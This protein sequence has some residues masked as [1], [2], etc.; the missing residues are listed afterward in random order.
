MD[1]RI[2]KLAFLVTFAT[3][4]A[5]C[6]GSPSGSEPPKSTPGVR[7]AGGDQV[8][9]SI[10]AT[11]QQALVV[12]VTEPNGKP[13]AG[14]IV[15]FEAVVAGTGFDQTPSMW[16]ASVGTDVFEGFTA[17]TTDAEGRASVR[18]RMGSHAGAGAVTITVP[19]Y[20]YSAIAQ[21]TVQPG[22]AWAVTATPGDTT[23]YVGR[24]VEMRATVADRAGNPRADAVTFAVASGPVTLS[25]GK[26]LTTA[27][28]GRGV[29]VAQVQA[30]ADTSYVSVIPEGT[31]AGFTSD[32]E[33]YTVNLDGTGL[34]LLAQA[35]AGRGYFG[36]MPAA[37]SA[38]GKSLV[39]HDSRSDHNRML[40][41]VDL[42][43]G[44][45]TLLIAEP[46]GLISQAWPQRS[47]DGQ[48]VYFNGQGTWQGAYVGSQLF[49]VRSDGTGA[50]RVNTGGAFAISGYASPS[51]DG[52]RLAF[53]TNRDFTSGGLHVL[54]LATGQSTALNISAA[55]PRW[56]PNG[57][58]IAYVAMPDGFGFMDNHVVTGF[59][60]LRVVRPDGTGARTVTRTQNLFLPGIGWSPDGKYLIGAGQQ[61]A[62]LTVVDVATGEEVR[63][64]LPRNLRAPDW[65]P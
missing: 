47:R 25:A 53:L 37:W 6:S 20:G 57:D 12:Q 30:V 42:A 59:G 39:Y 19:S 3:T 48:W 28:V 29:V 5:A 4:G 33:L 63:I 56:S 62:A 17:A 1:L 24:T 51:P 11:P 27:A 22:A 26:T 54:D 46:D 50:E 15:Q 35:S 32:M 21:Y 65:R 41:S 64:R 16:M 7:V 13:A 31:I 49:R 43:S 8:T 55:T 2:L 58:L 23:L 18:V 45:R 10:D 40:Y 44:I 52:S 14:T 60:E 34:R 36:E 61:G 38:D 9:D